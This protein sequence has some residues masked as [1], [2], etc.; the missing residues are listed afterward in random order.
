MGVML[1]GTGLLLYKNYALIVKSSRPTVMPVAF[2]EKLAAAD[3]VGAE[4]NVFKA[5]SSLPLGGG[6]EKEAPPSAIL[7]AK[8]SKILDISIFDSEEFKSLKE[9]T[10]SSSQKIEVG[11]KDPFEPYAMGE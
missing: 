7:P 1:S 11:K 8:I 2:D 9:N 4:K 3:L 6:K 10:A 5:T